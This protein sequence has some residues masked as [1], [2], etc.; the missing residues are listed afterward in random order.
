MRHVNSRR[1]GLAG[2]LIAAATGCGK[3]AA[4]VDEGAAAAAVAPATQAS[5]A[6]R[7]HAATEAGDVA[8]LDV[9]A[10]VRL[11]ATSAALVAIPARAQVMG[12]LVR[13][14]DEVRAGQVL[15]EVRLPELVVAAAQLRSAEERIGAHKRWAAELREL[16]RDGLA[17]SA[18]VFEAEARL[19]DLQAERMLAEAAIRAAGLQGGDASALAS[20]QPWPVKA[21]RQGQ[22]VG[23]EVVLGQ[24]V[25]NGAPLL[26]LQSAG[27]VRIEVRALQALPA[28]AQLEFVAQDGRVL[29]LAA[30]PTAVSTDPADGAWLGWYGLRQPQL[31]AQGLRGRVRLK[32]LAGGAVQ[33][34]ARALIHAEGAGTTQASVIVRTPA[35]VRLQKVEV[36]ALAGPMAIVRGIEVGSVVAAEADRVAL[37]DAAAGPS[38]SAGTGPAATPA[39]TPAPA[40]AAA[41]R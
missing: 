2:W 9:P 14:G 13:V 31:L 29:E 17:K 24:L 8:L 33:V 30:D 32:R 3:P 38:A 4:P 12:L 6:T 23:I 18:E 36:V 1:W 5:A 37:P 11:P 41:E 10:V 15:A 40:T 19:A 26:R 34:P 27:E 20:G 39:T 35:G 22:V 28:Q 25:E 7:W 21:Q 16:R